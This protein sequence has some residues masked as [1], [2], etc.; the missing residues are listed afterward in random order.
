MIL[1][2]RMTLVFAVFCFLGGLACAGDSSGSQAL[3]TPPTDNPHP[4]TTL[5]DKARVA[6]A[7]LAVKQL[8]FSA[9]GKE[10][11]DQTS[12]S[13][14][15]NQAHMDLDQACLMD[16]LCWQKNA[17][18]VKFIEDVK[19]VYGPVTET[20]HAHIIPW[21][22]QDFQSQKIQKISQPS[23]APSQSGPSLVSDAAKSIAAE[24]MPVP[25]LSAD[26]YMIH[27]YVMLGKRRDRWHHLDVIVTEDAKG[28]LKL[29]RF[30]L[31]PME[32]S[33]QNLPPGVVC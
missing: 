4:P 29:R 24:P 26:E 1:Q 18:A 27:M 14:N 7:E 33:N 23:A 10:T 3:P 31:V 15:G 9:T 13:I 21:S 2:K 22:F 25:V 20:R 30:Y 19:Y 5:E 32:I 8:L 12:Y 17:E 28:N 11:S 6:F 16:A